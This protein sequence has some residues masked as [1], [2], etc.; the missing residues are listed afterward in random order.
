MPKYSSTYGGMK[1]NFRSARARQTFAARR[2]QSHWRRKRKDNI[3]TVKDVRDAVNKGTPGSVIV[4]DTNFALT[5][6]VGP[7]GGPTVQHVL[8]DIEFSNSNDR[9]DSRKS[10]KISVGHLSCRCY[11]DVADRTNLCRVLVVRN[12][13]PQ[14]AAAFNPRNMF[15][16]NN[17]IGPQP[18][19][20]FADVNL[21]QVEVKYDKV[22]N[23]QSTEAAAP[24][25]RQQNIY[26]KFKIPIHETWKYFTETN[27]TSELTRNMKDYYIVAFSDSVVAP[28]PS[29]RCVSYLWFKN[30]TR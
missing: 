24:A 26:F 6:Q 19:Q 15:I 16:F 29:L 1:L 20:I 21:R 2:I 4:Q 8:S 10:K 22:F 13:D 30:H 14:T 25:T 9:P 18:D 28:N 12:R 7:L 17:G 5:A 27:N 11:L 23:L 3:K